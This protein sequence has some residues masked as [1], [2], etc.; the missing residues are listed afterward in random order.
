MILKT[1]TAAN[2]LSASDPVARWRWSREDYLRLNELGFFRNTRVQRIEGEIFRMSPQSEPHGYGVSQLIDWL[3][4][5]SVRKRF[6]IRPQFP[7]ALEDSDP[8]PDLALVLRDEVDGV[9]TPSHAQLVVEVSRSSLEF[10]RTVKLALYARAG[11]PEYWIVDVDGRRL[12][13]YR[14]P[15]TGADGTA[16]YAE[17][18]VLGPGDQIAP[19]FQADLVLAIEKLFP[20]TLNAEARGSE[21]K[22]C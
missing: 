13:V 11:I 3:Q 14:Q 7:L 19:L 2:P 8:E 6:Q 12:E 16:T 18:I 15:T 5:P 22:G 9:S 1:P 10:D 17:R 20:P 21:P 4:V